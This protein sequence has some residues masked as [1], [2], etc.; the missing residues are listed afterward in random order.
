MISCVVSGVSIVPSA[1]DGCVDEA[2]SI[3]IGMYENVR[4]A[5]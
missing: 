1:C 2:A 5:I 3:E 4:T